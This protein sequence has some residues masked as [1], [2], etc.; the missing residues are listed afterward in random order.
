MSLKAYH[1]IGM[2][3]VPKRPLGNPRVTFPRATPSSR[4]APEPPWQ[5]VS[6]PRFRHELIHILPF[7]GLLGRAEA[8]AREKVEPVSTLEGAGI[9]VTS[10][11]QPRSGAGGG[12]DPRTLGLEET[13]R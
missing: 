4:P 13:H 8:K 6:Y 12:A 2:C 3:Q 11:A 10:S 7:E 9:Y 5:V 1:V